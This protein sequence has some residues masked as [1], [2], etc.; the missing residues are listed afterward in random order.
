MPYCTKCGNMMSDRD[1]FCAKCGERHSTPATASAAAGFQPSPPPPM[2]SHQPFAYK[3][4]GQDP[5]AALTPR[6]ASVLPYIPAIGWIFSVIVL[7]GK[8]FR[9]DRI[10]RFHAFQGLYISALWLLVQWVIH[11]MMNSVG[12]GFFRVDRLLEAILIGTSIFMMVKAGHDEA[13][14][15]PVIGELAQRSAQE[16]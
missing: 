3:W 6:M 8:K 13:Y 9:L 14:V 16:K 10:V 5:L 11:P 4:N 1:L 7:A 2:G 12:E 15:L